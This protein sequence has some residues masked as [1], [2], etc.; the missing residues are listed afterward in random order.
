MAKKKRKKRERFFFLFSNCCV[1]LKNGAVKN[2]SRLA[3]AR[4]I[5][6]GNGR[7]CFAAPP[8][9]LQFKP[10]Q[11]GAFLLLFLLVSSPPRRHPGHRPPFAL[12]T[13]P[14]FLV[15]SLAGSLRQSSRTSL[16]SFSSLADP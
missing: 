8:N 11:N 5:Q 12:E 10:L 3:A 2:L 15:V 1:L 14:P 9:S 6:E 16:L 13:P 7:V 4:T